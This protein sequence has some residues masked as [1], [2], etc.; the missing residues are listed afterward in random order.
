MATIA[1]SHEGCEFRFSA[2]GPIEGPVR[3]PR[4][5]ARPGRAYRFR[6]RSHCG[7]GHPIEF[8]FDGRFW[9]PE[10][11]RYRTGVSAPR[12]FDFNTD[13]GTMT[14]VDGDTARYVSS[15]GRTVLFEPFDG[16]V[17]PL[18]CY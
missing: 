18:L 5:V 10:R 6:I 7:I 11:A 3:D 1:V 17:K 4:V 16:V 2:G 9:V 13:V 14:P 8:E 15:G 12:G